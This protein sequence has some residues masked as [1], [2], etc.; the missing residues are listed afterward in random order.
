[1]KSHRVNSYQEEILN[2]ISKYVNDGKRILDSVILKLLC[3]TDKTSLFD[4]QAEL[5]L[6]NYDK[7]VSEEELLRS[8]H[9]LNL[10][11]DIVRY[12]SKM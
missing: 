12:K 6:F 2:A 5:K 4:I 1:M 9:C 8:L 10:N 7:H 11:F 3:T